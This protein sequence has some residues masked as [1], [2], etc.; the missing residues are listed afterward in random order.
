MIRLNWKIPKP[1]SLWVS[2][3]YTEIQLYFIFN[4]TLSSVSPKLI[5]ESLYLQ[6][7]SNTVCYLSTE[8]LTLLFRQASKVGSFSQNTTIKLCH[9]E[10]L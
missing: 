1:K 3:K 2:K 9:Q 7:I 6:K 4:D 8:S 5:L 10:I